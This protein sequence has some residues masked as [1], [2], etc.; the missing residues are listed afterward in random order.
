MG[1]PDLIEYA[2]SSSTIGTG[3]PKDAA[4]YL[5]VAGNPAWQTMRYAMNQ[6]P[7][8]PPV[9]IC[10]CDRHRH[11][12]GLFPSQPPDATLAPD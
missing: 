2:T 7:K 9:G 5:I 1:E 10:E 12:H 3:P 8:C 4:P 6:P 11:W